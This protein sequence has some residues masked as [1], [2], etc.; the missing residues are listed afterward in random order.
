MIGELQYARNGFRMLYNSL[1]SRSKYV[2]DTFVR[3]L[4]VIGSIY[5]TKD[6]LAYMDDYL[7]NRGMDYDDILYPSRTSGAQGVGGSMNYV[8]KNIE[9]LYR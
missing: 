1:D 8:S 2:W 9:K 3:G 4:P 5:Q 6:N 7:E